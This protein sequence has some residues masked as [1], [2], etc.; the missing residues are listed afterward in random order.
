MA[1]DHVRAAVAEQT[2]E[3]RA[4]IEWQRR[5]RQ[6]QLEGSRQ[7]SSLAMRQ[8]LD[9]TRLQAAQERSAMIEEHDAE[10]SAAVAEVERRA[11][12]ERL[13]AVALKDAELHEANSRVGELTDENEELKSRTSALTQETLVLKEHI[14]RTESQLAAASAANQRLDARLASSKA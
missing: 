3:A 1:R 7:A 6:E 10:R 9:L 8:A 4:V 11:N 2:D 5:E 12:E 14:R 13:T